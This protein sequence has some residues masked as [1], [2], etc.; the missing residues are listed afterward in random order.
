MRC[1]TQDNEF[2][3]CAD[4]LAMAGWWDEVMYPWQ[5]ISHTIC[6]EEITVAL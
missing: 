5:R 3:L 4:C 6:L 2:G 1:L